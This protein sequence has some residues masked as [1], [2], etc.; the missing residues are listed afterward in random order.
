MNAQKP[1]HRARA[2][3]LGPERRRPAVLDAAL[4]IAVEQG[5]AAVTMGAI[6]DRLQVAR[7]VVYACFPDR[8]TLLTALIEREEEALILGALG[9]LPRGRAKADEAVFIEGFQALL[10]VIS[11]RPNTWRILMDATPDQA[12]ADRFKWGRAAIGT[13]FAR[14]LRPTLAY[15]GTVDPELKLPILVEQF[16]SICEG[17]VRSMLNDSKHEWTPMTL[18]AFVG[19]STYRAFRHA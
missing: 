17:A 1:V 2:A 19:A 10:T 18:G 9:A 12:V 15:W 3:H 5:V 16:M 13:H 11:E 4:E 7:T 14:L 8:V 6:A